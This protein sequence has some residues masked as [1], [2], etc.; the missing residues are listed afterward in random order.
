VIALDPDLPAGA[1][2][3]VFEAAPAIPGLGWRLDDTPLADTHG[4]VSWVPAP[5]RH[6]LV[7]TD[8]SGRAVSRVEFDVRGVRAKTGESSDN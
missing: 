1:Q 4:R 7:L 5:G 2:R 3:V 8:P 6:T